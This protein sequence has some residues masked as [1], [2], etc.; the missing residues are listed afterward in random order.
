MLNVHVLYVIRKVV[1]L[2]LRRRIPESGCSIKIGQNSYKYYV[3]INGRGLSAF[4]G[5]QYSLLR[6]AGGVVEAGASYMNK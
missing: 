5:E 3:C 4:S 2:I 1:R 6:C